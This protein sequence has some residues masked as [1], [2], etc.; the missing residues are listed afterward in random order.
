[1]Y[2]QRFHLDM[3]LTNDIWP[4]YCRVRWD[5]PEIA[6]AAEAKN[7]RLAAEQNQLCRRVGDVTLFETDQLVRSLRGVGSIPVG[8]SL[9]SCKGSWDALE[10]VRH[11]AMSLGCY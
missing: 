9:I 10:V 4:N 8:V 2:E 6:A 1:M 7:T 5:S 3:L 11:S